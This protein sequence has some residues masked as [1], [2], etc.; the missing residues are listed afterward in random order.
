FS[1]GSF[2]YDLNFIAHWIEAAGAGKP[3]TAL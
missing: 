1:Q 3:F 2:D